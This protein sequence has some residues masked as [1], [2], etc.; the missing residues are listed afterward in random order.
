VFRSVIEPQSDPAMRDLVAEL[1][2]LEQR[3]LRRHRRLLDSSQ[4]AHVRV[5]GREYLSF[6]SNDYL[7]L[8]A[9][10]RIADA[11][12]ASMRE[13][14]LGAGASHLLSGHHRAH[15][16]LERALAKFAGL[17]RAL[18]FSSG[19]LANLAVVTVLARRSSD[20]FADRLN[21]ASLNDAMILSRARCKRY[22][23]CDLAAL[24]SFLA[25]SDAAAKVV[26]T[27]A[28]FSMDGDIAPLSDIA[29]LCE[30]YGAWLVVDDAHGFGVL[31]ESGGGALDH[32]GL[33]SPHIAYVGTLGKAAGVSGAFVAGSEELIEL[34]IQRAR[35]YIYTTASPPPLAAALMKSV[36]LMQAE[37]WRRR[38]L[39]ELSARISRRLELR[40]WRLLP[41][42]TA[43]QPL[44]VGENSETVALSGALATEGILVP[45]I[46]PPTVP[47]GSARLRISL[48]AAHTQADV[49]L[50]I[51]TLRRAE[52]SFS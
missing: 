6:C 22:A 17:P 8:A 51:D 5:D 40:R 14:G 20:V 24:E 34:L 32:F 35:A 30:R 41:S 21:H 3:G 4:G 13:F 39:I 50:L 45:A 1:A 43:I 31:G 27:D 28:V 18:L 49:D 38:R 9:D 26:I 52:E 19:Y 33:D 15:D 44:I 25:R 48:S 37:D 23:H 12:A 7:G 47:K 46:R 2:D 36:E 29:R 42:Q 11:A 10:P 16:D